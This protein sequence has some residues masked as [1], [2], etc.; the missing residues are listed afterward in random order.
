MS[1]DPQ[2]VATGHVPK[3]EAQHVSKTFERRGQ[4]VTA[5]DD[6]SLTVETGEFVSLVGASGC[7]KTTLLR[8]ID[9]LEDVTSGNI[10][11]NG[12]DVT[13]P[14]GDRGFVFQEDTL[15]PWRTIIKNV[16]LGGE[17]QG[18]SKRERLS[19]ARKFIRLVGLEGFENHYPHELSGGMRQRANLAR[20][21]AVDPD[22]LLM[23]EPFA[24]LDA[25]TRE[26]M[27]SELLR[28]W[29]AAR[30]TVLFVTHQ[31]DEAIYLSDRVVV[32]T[33]RPGR[34]KEIIPVDLPRPRELN[35]KRT[36]EFTTL[37]DHI[38]RLIEQ[39]VKAAMGVMSPADE[40]TAMADEPVQDV[41]ER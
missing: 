40:E 18:V 2:T 9:G 29:S 8:I 28:I 10:R 37:V 34:I 39:E 14:G 6:V 22:V 23:D 30:R 13:H 7:G 38:W 26:I 27:Q 21:F 20:A 31:I 36:P 15:F 33:A 35:I 4:S 25:Q 12:H 32:L 17:L 16:S 24:A 41:S 19:T 11:L 1:A 5:L 3:L